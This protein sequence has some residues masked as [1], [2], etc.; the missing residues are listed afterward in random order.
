MGF[1]FLKLDGHSLEDA[2]NL[3]REIS[4]R[5]FGDRIY[6]YAPSFIK[7]ENA[8]FAS[9]PST[10][11]SISITGSFCSL[12][13]KHCQGKILETMIPAQTPSDL[14]KVCRRLKDRGCKGCLISGGSLPDG[15]VPLGRFIKAIAKIK[16]DLGL[17]V[18]V[19]T[20][21]I[22][23]DVATCLREA[24]VD[25]ALI[26]IVGSKDTIK[27]VYHLNAKV[28]DYEDSLKALHS[29]KIPIVPHVLV[30]LHYG[31]V[32][33]EF[34]AL[35]IISE[36]SPAAIIIIA[37]MPLKGTIMEDVE[38][39]KPK[40]VAKV[41]IAARMMMPSKPLIL[42]CARPLG[43]HRVE[44]DLLAVR[45]GVNAIAFPSEEAIQF[46][47]SIGLK[48]SFSNLCCSQIY[49]DIKEFYKPS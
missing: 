7:Y 42:G 25:A 4:R 46:A 13:C 32:K 17:K 47:E 43:G 28:E 40:E 19:H 20:G 15:S 45:A 35:E 29:L 30:G 49:E 22:S 9:S 33:G 26:D 12:K 48:A 8:Y 31:R 18:V 23:L 6:F 27:D 41:L 16:K 14:L 36:Y 3:S 10:F 39:P 37:F 44:T 11:P 1:D 34:K 21:L 2:L 5:H 38:P 24:G